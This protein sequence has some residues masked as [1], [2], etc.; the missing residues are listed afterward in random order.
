MYD[1]DESV[2]TGRSVTSSHCHPVAGHP[3]TRTRRHRRQSYLSQLNQIMQFSFSNASAG[4]AAGAPPPSW[5]DVV[6]GRRH[7]H[8]G[9]G[10]DATRSRMLG[11]VARLPEVDDVGDGRAGVTHSTAA[12]LSLRGVSLGDDAGQ[13]VVTAGHSRV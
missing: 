13:V 3:A 8:L 12:K 11:W 2:N 7:N 10:N 9:Y 4:L 6:A 1:N 5:A